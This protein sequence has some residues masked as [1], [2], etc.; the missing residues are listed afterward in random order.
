MSIVLL[1]PTGLFLR[2][3]QNFND[4]DIGFKRDHLALVSITLDP[5]RY[6]PERG[7]TTYRDIAERLRHIPGVEQ[8]DFASTV[9]L[10]GMSN[11]HAFL[12]AGSEQAAWVVESNTVGPHYFE[13]M[14]I[15]FLRGR[16]LPGS[17]RITP[18]QS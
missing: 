18:W 4:L 10:S 12:K 17:A 8:A 13:T 9:P 14:G 16:D 1:M 15:P 3:L 6:T 5:E 7:I 2:S 11:T